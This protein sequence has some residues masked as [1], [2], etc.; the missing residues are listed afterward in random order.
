MPNS[1]LGL[2]TYTPTP[3]GAGHSLAYTQIGARRVHAQP[4]DGHPHPAWAMSK[5]HLALGH[6]RAPPDTR[7]MAKCLIGFAQEPPSARAHP[8]ATWHL[9]GS[10]AKGRPQRHLAHECVINIIIFIIIYIINKFEKQ[11]L[12]LLKNISC[13]IIIIMVKSINITNNIICVIIIIIFIIIKIINI[14][15]SVIFYYNL[16]Y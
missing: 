4:H 13:V 9:G 15:N 5:C 14:K 16:Y 7:V 1:T 8:S 10:N 6:N 3:S 11:I 12:L 2:K